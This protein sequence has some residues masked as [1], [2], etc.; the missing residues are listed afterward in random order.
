MYVK[1]KYQSLTY[2]LMYTKPDRNQHPFRHK[3]LFLFLQSCRFRVCSVVCRVAWAA[4]LAAGIVAVPQASANAQAEKAQSKPTPEVLLIDIY[5]ELAAQRLRHAQAKADV[6]V[7]T[8]PNF[9]LGH[10]IRGDLLLM[11]TRPVTRFGAAQDA[12]AE[13]LNDLREEAIA[14]LKSLRERPDPRL[15]P[16]AV[17][18]LRDDQKHVLMVDA[19]RS[20]L[21]VYEHRAGQLRFATDYYIS[22]GKLG[23][24]K[25]KEGDKKTPLGVYYITSHLPGTRLPDFYGPGAL[26]INYPNE[27]DKVNGRGG[28]GIWLHGTASD[29]FSRPPLASDGCVVLANDDL[30]E[31]FQS[32]EVGK[33]PVVISEHVEFVDQAKRD[34]DR[35]M[36]LGLVE[37]WRS[38]LAGRDAVRLLAH[39]STRFKTPRGEDLNA[40]FVKQRHALAQAAALPGPVRDATFFF[41]PG[42]TNTLVATFTLQNAAGKN[43]QSVRQRQYWSK[44]GA[45][46]KIVSETTL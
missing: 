30:R 41:Y 24:D 46:W 1:V 10:L 17:L 12:A 31:L 7:A 27:W 40:W 3:R 39:Y 23:V 9:R 6:L 5:K 43:R 29:T 36:A 11:H 19:K 37:A 33:T 14:R 28:S 16:R 15:V 25:F 21:Y 38:A 20:R 45:A 18:Q 4:L 26:P 42:Q 13:E 44:E 35:K 32:V 22:Q 34:A 2:S 8:Y